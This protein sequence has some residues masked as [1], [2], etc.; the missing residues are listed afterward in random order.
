VCGEAQKNIVAAQNLV[1]HTEKFVVYAEGTSYPSIS[2]LEIG[3]TLWLLLK[4]GGEI[5]PTGRCKNPP[6]IEEWA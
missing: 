1:M 5:M 3:C 6:T 2:L 4:G